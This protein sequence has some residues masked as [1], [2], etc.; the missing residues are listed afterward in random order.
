MMSHDCE[1][2]ASCRK[3][4]QKDNLSKSYCTNCSSTSSSFA[5][6][7][8]PR[9]LYSMRTSNFTPVKQRVMSA[10]MLK[11][12]QLQSQL[13]DANYH[14]SEVARENRTLKTLQK[15]QDTVLS[16]YESTNADFPRLI[17]SHEE[18]VRA[19]TEGSK[20][21]KITVR[22]LTAQLKQKENELKKAKGQLIHLEK[23]DRDKHLIEREKLGEMLNDCKI[24]LEKCEN[25]VTVLNRKLMLESKI[26]KQRLNTEI[27]KHRQTQKELV[28]ALEEI[29]LLNHLL[30]AKCNTVRPRNPRFVK[31][32]R[33]YLPINVWKSV[34]TRNYRNDNL[35]SQNP[36]TKVQIQPL[37]NGSANKREPDVLQRNSEKGLASETSVITAPMQ[38]IR[39]RLSSESVSNSLPPHENSEVF[40]NNYYGADDLKR[41]EIAGSKYIKS[42]PNSSVRLEKLVHLEENCRRRQDDIEHDATD[43]ETK[44]KDSVFVGPNT[45]DKKDVMTKFNSQTNEEFESL[46]DFARIEKTLKDKSLEI[47]GNHLEDVITDNKQNIRKELVDNIT[48]LKSRSSSLKSTESG[49]NIEK[50]DKDLD[51]DLLLNVDNLGINREPA[52]F[53]S[54]DA[55]QDI[56]FYQ[57]SLE[58][59]MNN[60]KKL[61][62]A[63]QE[64]ELRESKLIKT[65]FNMDNHINMV[66][67]VLADTCKID[68][69]TEEP[70]YLSD[71]KPS[72]KSINLEKKTKLL[73]TLRAIDNGDSMDSI[74]E[75]KQNNV[76]E[77]IF[78]GTIM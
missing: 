67:G 40:P 70:I 47:S 78:N 9:N 41:L 24:K 49:E 38:N 13:S 36:V 56:P 20:K 61:S 42:R 29:N 74:E 34:K 10:T 75:S 35:N 76:R 50:I 31:L 15:R 52:P 77:T 39:Q 66:N 51:S 28:G 63:L 7:K 59:L 53:K 43:L 46:K 73:A 3:S 14:L 2:N 58:L 23:L 32:A 48:T 44:F 62:N 1:S 25:Q 45:L 19:L 65:F 21:L 4:I 27:A 64:L 18:E 12:K 57:D 16:K 8:K 17:H 11:I 71:K 68:N 55:S 6:Y 26:F 30:E 22:S 69:E 37:F 60:D 5:R 72:L 33:D 54:D